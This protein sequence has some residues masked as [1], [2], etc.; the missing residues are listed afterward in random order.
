MTGARCAAPCT[1][2]GTTTE[3]TPRLACVAWHRPLRRGPDQ[4]PETSLN[5][6]PRSLLLRL[7]HPPQDRRLGD[8]DRDIGPDPAL[9]N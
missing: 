1:T 7:Y 6:A 5:V 3:Q 2:T 8:R 4:Q 9:S